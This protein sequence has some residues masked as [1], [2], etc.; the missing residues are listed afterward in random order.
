MGVADPRDS[1]PARVQGLR[2]VADAVEQRMR[3]RRGA[4]PMPREDIE[5]VVMASVALS[6]GYALMK[7]ALYAAMGREATPAAEEDFRARAAELV[8]QLV[9]RRR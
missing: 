3:E 4:A 5:F 9:S 7:E 2:L 6:Y 8:E 1:F